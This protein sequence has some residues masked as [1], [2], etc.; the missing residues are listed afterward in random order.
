LRNSRRIEATY[1][2][3]IRRCIGFHRLAHPATV[4]AAEISAFLTWLAIHQ[5]VS[6][7]TQNQALAAV[8]FLY[9]QVLRIPV[10]P[11]EHVVRAKEP[12]RL[13]VV[14]SRSASAG[15]LRQTRGSPSREYAAG[16]AANTGTVH[17]CESANVALFR[18]PVRVI[19]SRASASYRGWSISGT[20]GVGRLAR[21]GHVQSNQ[22]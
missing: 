19:A 4:G 6:A 8:L 1:A 11:V 12:L 3:W 18:D 7:S 5:H 15:L 13:L 9:E 17:E 20:A 2:A 14:L 21:L 10:G 22:C 16:V